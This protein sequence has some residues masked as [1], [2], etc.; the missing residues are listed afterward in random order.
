[1]LNNILLKVNGVPPSLNEVLNMHW[2]QRN[3]EKKDWYNKI[4]FEINHLKLKKILKKDIVITLTYYFKTKAFHDYDNYS[5]KFVCDSLKGNLI[6]DDSQKY[7]KEL[8]IRFALAGIGVEPYT[9]IEL[10]YDD[11]QS[12]IK[13]II[14]S[15]NINKKITLKQIDKAIEQTNEIRRYCDICGKPNQN[16]IKGVD[17]VSGKI[18]MFC[19]KCMLG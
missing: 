5:G 17:Q 3:K 10:S 7:I 6:I 12:P 19:G 8:R 1:M 11:C 13:D 15:K 16:L 9:T 18:I 4:L 2:A 14:N